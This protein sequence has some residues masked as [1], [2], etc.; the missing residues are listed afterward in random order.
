MT[1]DLWTIRKLWKTYIRTCSPY[2]PMLRKPACVNKMN[3]RLVSG[4]MRSSKEPCAFSRV[5]IFPRL[6]GWMPRLYA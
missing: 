5:P 1:P 2:D 3:D 4:Y 6:Q